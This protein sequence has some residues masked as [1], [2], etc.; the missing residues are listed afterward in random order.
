MSPNHRRLKRLYYN[1]NLDD[2]TIYRHPNL[3][4]LKSFEYDFYFFRPNYVREVADFFEDAV[5]PGRLTRS[6]SGGS[7][8]GGGAGQAITSSSSQ[9]AIE[10]GGGTRP[11]PRDENKPVGLPL[12]K[13][14]RA[15][16]TIKPKRSTSAGAVQRSSSQSA[17]QRLCRQQQQSGLDKTKA[18]RTSSSS[19]TLSRSPITSTALSSAKARLKRAQ[20]TT[21]LVR[22]NLVTPNSITTYEAAVTKDRYGRTDCVRELVKHFEA[23]WVK[24]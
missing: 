16:L 12:T 7:S 4:W 13:A 17:V 9:E 3:R 19:T 6:G 21:D 20:S 1:Y 15:P 2:P 11:E 10:G 23:D 24:I 8:S 18:V 14:V 5:L 22:E